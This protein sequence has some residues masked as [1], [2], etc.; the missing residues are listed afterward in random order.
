MNTT[1]AS[2][3]AFFDPRTGTVSYVVWDP[4]SLRA[5]GD[6]KSVV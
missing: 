3:Q 2:V 5:A 4:A 1:S 6:R